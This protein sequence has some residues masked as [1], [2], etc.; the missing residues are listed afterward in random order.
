MTTSR[1]LSVCL[2]C[3]LVAA[4]VSAA[5]SPVGISLS[6]TDV[7]TRLGESFNF[8]SQIRNTGT[9]PLSGLVAH[10]NVVGLDTDIYVDPEDW[11]EERTK[12]V[13]SLGPGESTDVTWD[14]TAVTGGEAAIYVVVLPG[15][16]PATSREGL[17]V[18]QAMDVRIAE[19]KNLNS[20]GVLPL[21]LGVPAV[22]AVAAIAVRRRRS[23]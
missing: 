19:A 11:S 8:D 13:A 17:A 9:R 3:L 23:R 15:D 22:L 14:V 18:S 7:S 2:F 4:P 10:L 21:A 5:S 20:G 6:R 16:S 12:S 1:A